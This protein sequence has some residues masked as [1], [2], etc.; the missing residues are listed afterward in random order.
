MFKTIK[1]AFNVW[2]NKDINAEEIVK[3]QKPTKDELKA[4]ITLLEQRRDAA[5]AR[6][7]PFIAIADFEV[8]YTSL[9]SGNFAFIWN[10]LFLARCMKRGYQGTVDHDLVDQFFTTV[11]RNVVMETYEQNQAD[12]HNRTVDIGGGRREYK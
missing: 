4:H 11:C 12:P 10:D 6:G 8:D 5:T 3:V 1:A 9:T 2:R 7:E